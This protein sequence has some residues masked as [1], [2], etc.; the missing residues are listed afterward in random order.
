MDKLIAVVLAGNLVASSG[1]LDNNFEGCLSNP[2]DYKGGGQR[3][4]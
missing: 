2:T 4:F 3:H 1:E